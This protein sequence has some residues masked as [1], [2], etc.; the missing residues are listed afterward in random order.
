M[1]LFLVVWH[2]AEHLSVWLFMFFFVHL[3]QCLGS[4]FMCHVFG[5]V[6]GDYSCLA[7]ISDHLRLWVLG[8]YFGSFN[9]C[10]LYV[11]ITFSRF[12]LYYGCFHSAFEILH[13]PAGQ[14]RRHGIRY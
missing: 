11:L 1:F 7:S 8:N 13:F 3:C 4:I 2:L 5:H 14:N 10:V 9:C 6:V 12:A